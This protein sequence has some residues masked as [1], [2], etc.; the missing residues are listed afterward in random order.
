MR[1]M[2][3][4]KQRSDQLEACIS[5]AELWPRDAAD[6]FYLRPAAP[7]LLGRNSKLCPIIFIVRRLSSNGYSR[8]R[9]I[10]EFFA[11]HLRSLIQGK[12]ALGFQSKFSNLYAFVNFDT[13]GLLPP[14]DNTKD[15]CDFRTVATLSLRPGRDFYRC[16]LV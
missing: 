7:K 13:K 16:V 4:D 14:S 15:E 6:R 10:R 9:E 11:C 1:L 3:T 5:R 12:L 8:D 2:A